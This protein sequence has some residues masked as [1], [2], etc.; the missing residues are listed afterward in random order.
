MCCR[1]ERYVYGFFYYLPWKLPN[2]TETLKKFYP[3]EVVQTMFYD[4]LPL[5]NV[6]GHCYVVDEKSYCEGRPRDCKGERDIYVCEYRMDKLH[7]ELK[8]ISSRRYETTC[9]L[10]YNPI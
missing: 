5:R 1:G 2:R 4:I 3:N 9:L 10:Y 7:K 8:K 6:R